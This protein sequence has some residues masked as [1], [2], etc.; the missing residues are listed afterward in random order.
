MNRPICVA[1]I[2][3]ERLSG[4]VDPFAMNCCRHIDCEQVQFDFLVDADSVL[5]SKEKVEF[6]D[7][8][9]FMMPPYQYL[10]AYER[11]L[12]HLFCIGHWLVVRSRVNAPSVFPLRAAKRAGVRVCIAHSHSGAAE[13]EIAKNAAK[14]VRKRFSNVY[15]THCAVCGRYAGEWLFGKG[16]KFEIVC[17]AIDL[18]RF[19]LDAGVRAQIRANLGLVDGQTAIGH[20]D[21]FAISKDHG[22]LIVVF[23]ELV[24]WQLDAVFL[25]VGSSEA[26]V[27]AKSW[28]AECGIA[29][30]V[31]FF[32]QRY[33][34]DRPYWTFSAF[35]LLGPYEGLCLVGVE[36]RLSGLPC[37]LL[38]QNTRGVDVMGMAGFLSIG[39]SRV[40]LDAFCEVEPV[41]CL[42]ARSGDF[43]SCD[44]DR[45]AERLAA[46]CL[47]LAEV[48]RRG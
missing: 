21:C 24:R 19:A 36:V 40:R 29:D 15:F 45:T 20:V 10:A 46:R 9:A 18:S 13:G 30:S 6:L 32:G 39:A 41:M 25:L 14:T 38:D 5:V 7:G 31:K 2:M 3:G 26:E 17:N 8:R 37:F 4:C 35:A 23:A 27:F 48:A 34:V 16:M 28:A 12:E 33:D 47:D 44:I 22:F 43:E 11:G 1:Q 42:L